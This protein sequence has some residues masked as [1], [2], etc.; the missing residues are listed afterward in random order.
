MHDEKR[1]RQHGPLGSAIVHT[2]LRYYKILNS[3]KSIIVSQLKYTLSQAKLNMK[4][5]ILAQP[6]RVCSWI[7]VD[8]EVLSLVRPTKLIYSLFLLQLWHSSVYLLER[9]T[10]RKIF[11]PMYRRY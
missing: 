5:R 6:A 7:N 9:W 11:Y 8:K 4:A 1:R 2:A 3:L 10:R